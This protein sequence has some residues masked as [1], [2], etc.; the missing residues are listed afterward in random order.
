MAALG[1]AL[2]EARRPIAILGGSRWDAEAAGRVQAFAERWSLPV[3]CSFR[4]QALFDNLHP[5]YAG[6]VGIAINPQLARRI[7]EAFDPDDRF[8]PDKVLPQGSRCFDF[9]RP[10]PEGT[11]V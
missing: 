1:E 5:C 6:D 10:I 11:W 4:R 2:I 9:G 3:A 8:N 7:K